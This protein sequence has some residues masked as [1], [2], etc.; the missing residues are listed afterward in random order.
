VDGSVTFSV[1]M[2]PAGIPRLAIAQATVTIAVPIP[3]ETAQPGGT[4]VK[5]VIVAPFGFVSWSVSVPPA[6][7]A[8][9]VVNVQLVTALLG[10]GV[11]QVPVALRGVTEVG[12]C[13]RLPGATPDSSTTEITNAAAKPSKA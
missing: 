11:V 7:T 5:P 13:A 8:T 9:V 2:V 1:R 3:E 12:T 4:P 6:A 10:G